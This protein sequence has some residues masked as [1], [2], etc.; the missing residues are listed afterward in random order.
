MNWSIAR[1]AT[2]KLLQRG[3]E[4]FEVSFSGGEPLLAGNLIRRTVAF[5][6]SEL[7]RDG[8]VEYTLTT[9]GTLLDDEMIGFLVEHDFRIQ[10]SFDG[11]RPAQDQRGRSSFDL[12]DRLIDQLQNAH[13]EYWET[14]VAFGVTLTVATIPFLARS[15]QY[16]IDKG[17]R[18]IEIQPIVTW[19]K[20]DSDSEGELVRQVDE[21]V[22]IS[23]SHWRGNRR[24]PVGFLRPME[25]RDPL[26]SEP[27]FACGACSGTGLTV[28]VEG[29]AWGCQLF[30]SSI[31]ELPP[32]GLE[33]AEVLDLG[34]IHDPGIEDRLAD[35]P[36]VAFQQ[37]VLRAVDKKWSSQ[38]QCSDCRHLASCHL[39]PA[40]TIHIPNNSDPLRIP[41]FPCA[42][43]RITLDAADAFARRISLGPI[44]DLL[45]DIKEPMRRL[46]QVLPPVGDGRS[47]R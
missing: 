27:V 16:F 37:P 30:S 4:N 2:E 20:W 14:H 29:R 24:V 5:V 38:G 26:I 22:G 19:Q 45:E 43:S 21:I 3:G 9:N 36:K 28:D 34:D 31:Q 44:F 11:I 32:L 40:S 8:S 12:L 39:C 1:K 23:E 17:V 25:P 6:E 41:D 35:L 18:H 42:F 10:I 13:P 33:V 15:I 7:P 47:P 46:E